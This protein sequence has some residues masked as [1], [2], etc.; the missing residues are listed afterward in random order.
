M[1]RQSEPDLRRSRPST[2]SQNQTFAQA[3][4][5]LCTGDYILAIYT[6]DVRM[7]IILWSTT[8]KGADLYITRRGAD[9]STTKEV[10]IFQRP[11]RCGSPCPTMRKRTTPKTRTAAADLSSPGSDCIDLT[12]PSQAE[13]NSSRQHN[14]DPSAPQLKEHNGF[15]KE[16]SM[17]LLSRIKHKGRYIRRTTTTLK[18][19]K[20][21]NE[22]L[23]L[24][25]HRNYQPIAHIGSSSKPQ[26]ENDPVESSGAKSKSTSKRKNI[27]SDTLRKP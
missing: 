25:K 27:L 9:L 2:D 17:E 3:V 15:T 26:Q 22:E 20:K 14:T 8:R 12:A 18:T 7:F 6:E 16:K 24:R 21:I 10:Q 4:L 11:T 1:S 19:R 13:A 23:A 5:V